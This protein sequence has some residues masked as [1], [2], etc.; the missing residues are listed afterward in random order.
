MK[1]TLNGEKCIKI[2][3]ISVNNR[4]TWKN[5]RSSLSILD[6]LIKPKNY[7]TLL[8]LYCKYMAT[9]FSDIVD[10]LFIHICILLPALQCRVP[11][12]SVL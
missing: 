4:T 12:V 1:N 2:W 5:I 9:V 11:L 3:H 6:V 10:S 8:S 7:L